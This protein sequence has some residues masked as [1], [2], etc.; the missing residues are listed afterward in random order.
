MTL[1][2]WQLPRSLA[3]KARLANFLRSVIN[4]PAL[5]QPNKYTE[6]DGSLIVL[7]NLICM[8]DLGWHAWLMCCGFVVLCNGCIT[9]STCMWWLAKHVLGVRFLQCLC[10]FRWHIEPLCTAGAHNRVV[11]LAA[12]GRSRCSSGR[13]F[14]VHMHCRGN[15]SLLLHVEA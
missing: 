2:S 7:A 15:F 9:W 5:D 13:R 1:N 11:L 4:G 3:C 12:T 8:C 10:W 14:V 6:K